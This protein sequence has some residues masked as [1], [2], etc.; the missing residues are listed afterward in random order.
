MKNLKGNQK[1]IILLV[2]K[3]AI[4]LICISISKKLI[5]RYNYFLISLKILVQTK[6]TMLIPMT[7]STWSKNTSVAIWD[8][9]NHHNQQKYRV[10]DK[11]LEFV[12]V[13]RQSRQSLTT[14][15]FSYH[16]INLLFA[17]LRGFHALQLF[18]LA[19]ASTQ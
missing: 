17:I 6:V 16:I 18:P 14:D 3:S 4:M 7:Q 8:C 1:I 2:D 12:N 5:Y 15:A 11:K 9:I 19:L 10:S 13:I